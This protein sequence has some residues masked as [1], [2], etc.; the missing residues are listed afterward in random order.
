MN[1][2]Y[3]HIAIALA[4]ATQS[5]ILVPQLAN[6]GICSATLYEQAIKSIFKTSPKTTDDVYDGIKNIKTGL[7][8]LIQLLSSGQK[9]HVQTIRYLFG[10][11]S[12]TNKLLKNKDALDKIDQRLK[13]ISGLYSD[14]NDQT[15]GINVDDISYSLAGIYSD[16][17]SPISTKI[18][19]IGKIEFLQNSL[20][21]AKVRTALLGCVRSAILWYQVGGSRFQFLF[22]RKRICDA[23]QQLLDQINR[24]N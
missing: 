7:Q 15:V 24:I 3:H 19:V 11:L 12:I 18:K 5:A 13:R 8:T 14:I 4:G 6:T 22:S 9:E 20:V 16:I 1:N 10:S 23:A 21:Q 17:I 2:K